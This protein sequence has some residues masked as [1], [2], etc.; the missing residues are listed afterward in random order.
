MSPGH[1]L[2]YSMVFQK[3]IK[4]TF[5]Q[6]SNTDQFFSAINC[7][8]YK[9][10]KFLVDILNPI[11]KNSYTV[12]N[13]ASFVEEITKIAG[14]DQYFM[15]SFDVKDLYPS[16]PLLE[17]IDICEKEYM[18]FSNNRGILKNY[19]KTFLELPVLNSV[20]LFQGKYFKQI[21]GLGMGLPL[22]PTLANIF[23]CHNEEKWLDSC[24]LLYKPVFYRRYMDDCFLLFRKK[25][26]CKHLLDYLNSKNTNIEFTVETEVENKIPFLDCLIHK[27]NDSFEVEVYRKKTFTGLGTSFFSFSPSIYKLNSIKTPIY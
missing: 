8:S 10:S 12:S 22:S 1:R 27:R 26:H 5:R 21:D 23:L 9:I 13:S 7:A 25:S 18:N 4:W 24:P 16:I 15:A 11:A 17:S 6:S 20:F 14:S 3:S 2:E 19:F